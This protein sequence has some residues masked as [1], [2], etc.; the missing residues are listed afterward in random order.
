MPM[1]ANRPL[2][3]ERDG[4]Y[5]GEMTFTCPMGAWQINCLAEKADGSRQTMTFDIA[6]V[7]MK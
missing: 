1:P 7:R 4:A 2:V 6:Q 3:T 5:G